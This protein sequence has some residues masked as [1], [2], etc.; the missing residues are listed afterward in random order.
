MD[1]LL[2]SSRALDL[3]YGLGWLCGKL[4]GYPSQAV[5]PFENN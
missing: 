5:V 4:L 3:T 1:S 2:K